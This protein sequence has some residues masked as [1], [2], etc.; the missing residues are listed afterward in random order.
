M[1]KGI[2]AMPYPTNEPVNSYA[3]GTSERDSL[4]SKYK[5]MLLSKDLIESMDQEFKMPYKL[6]IMSHLLYKNLYNML[7]IEKYFIEET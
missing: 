2:Y 7:E 1:P 5:E 6:L 3:P 4:L